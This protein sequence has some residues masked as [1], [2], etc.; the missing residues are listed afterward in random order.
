MASSVRITGNDQ[1]HD[2]KFEKMNWP[3]SGSRILPLIVIAQFFSTTLWFAGNSIMSDIVQN[4]HL[5]P[6]FLA[7]LTS[8][9]Q[10][11]F[12]TGTLVFA[13]LTISDRY[14]PS[15]VFFCK[16]CFSCAI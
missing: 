7:H 14:S 3:A 5:A 4:F 15:L 8:A 9:V 10:F 2:C 12:I 6:G 11:G 1:R 13:L 16:F